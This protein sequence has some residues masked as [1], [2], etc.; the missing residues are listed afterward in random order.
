MAT[1]VLVHG[2]GGGGWIYQAVARILRTNG[3][4]VYTPTLTGV[5][6]REH[7]LTPDVDLDMHVVD[8]VKLLEFENLTD[9]ILVGHSYGGMVITG[10]ADR[11][12]DRIGHLVFLDAAHP[13]NGESLADVAPGVMEHARKQS[14]V[15]DGIELVLLP[16]SDVAKAFGATRYEELAWMAKKL[17]PHPWKSFAQPLLLNNED[18]VL[19]LPKTNINCTPTLKLR[20]DDKIQRSLEGDN[21][22]EIDTAHDL[23]ISE[24]EKTAE[25]LLRVVQAT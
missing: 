7:L 13:H 12:L 18:A 23:M 17:R 5:G 24:P 3:H 20:A 19:G 9:V 2:G 11:A 4:E 10:V 16:D 22:W 1:F 14:K 21:V 8:V 6:D 15:I 25:F